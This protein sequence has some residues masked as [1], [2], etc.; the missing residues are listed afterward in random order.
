MDV[1]TY[2]MLG[3]QD[4][5]TDTLA[6]STGLLRSFESLGST[7]SYATG[8]SRS[9]SLTVNIIVPAVV[10]WA[11][12][13]PTTWAAWLVPDVPRGEILSDQEGGTSTPAESVDASG[14]VDAEGEARV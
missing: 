2:W 8:S 12:I 3:T 1:W 13:P 5:N 11:S 10:F 7:F 9:A 6:L 4:S 14:K